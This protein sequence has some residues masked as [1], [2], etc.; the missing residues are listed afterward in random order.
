MHAAQ[1]LLWQASE[2]LRTCGLTG[3]ATWTGRWE[4]AKLWWDEGGERAAD[5]LRL[6]KHMLD[7]L[8][9]ANMHS[10]SFSG[11]Q[12]QGGGGGHRNGMAVR[13]LRTVGRSG[14]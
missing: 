4:Q 5:A 13:V 2:H 8:D 12:S 14:D 3:A 7:E 10:G 6:A 1:S 9:V 11:S